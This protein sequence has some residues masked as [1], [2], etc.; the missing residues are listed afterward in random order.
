MER[1][2]WGETKKEAE[3]AGKSVTKAGRTVPHPR[4]KRIAPEK[5]RK[6][7]AL[8]EKTYAINEVLRRYVFLPRVWST[9]QR[10]WVVLWDIVPRSTTG[11][12]LRNGTLELNDGIALRLILDFAKAG[13]L[14]RFRRCL[15]CRKWLYAKFRHQDFC[16][17]GC[18]QKHYA[19]SPEW[20]AKRRD[21]MREY[22]RRTM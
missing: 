10:P 5:Y 4:L 12:R 19:K 16:C 21:Y 13:H 2:L 20:R 3:F 6:E 22:R 15:H 7:L 14:N 17:T 18:Q 11:S 1:P 9:G 8:R